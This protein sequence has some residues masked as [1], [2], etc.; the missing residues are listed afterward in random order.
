MSDWISTAEQLPDDEQTVLIAMEDGEVWT[1]FMDAGEWRYVSA[2]PVGCA[3]T[4]WREFPEPPMTSSKQ[5]TE[6]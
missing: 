1:G 5:R 2:D 6:E 3:V 4:H